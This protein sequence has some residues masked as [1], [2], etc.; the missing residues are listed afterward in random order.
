MYTHPEPGVLE[1]EAKWAL[2]NITLNKGSGGDG[3][4]AKLFQ[5]LKHDAVT[6]LH[7]IYQQIWKTQQWPQDWERSVFKEEGQ[8]KESSNYHT[9]V[10]ISLKLGFNST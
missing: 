2:G 1:C 9:I 4:P 8:D 6:V 7:S 5:I 10:V 3:I